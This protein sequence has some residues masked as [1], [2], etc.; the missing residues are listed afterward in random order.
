[1]TDCPKCIA[2]QSRQ[3]PVPLFIPPK[4]EH[5]IRLSPGP[6]FDNLPG[7]AQGLRIYANAPYGWLV[8][9][10]DTPR[11]F[12]RGGTPYDDVLGWA[13]EFE[14]ADRQVACT[15]IGNWASWNTQQRHCVSTVWLG[16]DHSFSGRGRLIFETMVFGG[17]LDQEQERYATEDEARAGHARWVA[18]ALEANRLWHR[19]RRWLSRYLPSAA[20]AA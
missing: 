5:I 14:T 11:Y 9:S 13:R 2:Q 17:A 19:V 16:L 12:R 3:L 15:Y 18:A 7:L 10:L 8:V 20:S 6:F 1:M 4:G